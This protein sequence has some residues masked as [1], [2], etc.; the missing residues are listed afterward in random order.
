MEPALA[1]KE[2]NNSMAKEKKIS[3]EQFAEMGVIKSRRNKPVT[4]SYLYRLIRKH[5]KG[6]VLTIPFNYIMEGEKDRI[7]IVLN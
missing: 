6:E 3:V 1:E 5:N 4:L 7:W 2:F